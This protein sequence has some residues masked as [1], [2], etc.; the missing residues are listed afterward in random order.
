MSTV[1]MCRQPA[2]PHT[3]SCNLIRPTR[4]SSPNLI[5]LSRLETI[6]Q[7][8][9]CPSASQPSPHQILT[10]GLP[11]L[12]P[13]AVSPNRLSTPPLLGR[14]SDSLPRDGSSPPTVLSGQHQSTVYLSLPLCRMPTSITKHLPS[15]RRAKKAFVLEMP[16][17]S[18]PRS[19]SARC[20]ALLL[21]EGFRPEQPAGA[22]IGGTPSA[23][24]AKVDRNLDR[25]LD[26]RPPR[27]QQHH[28]SQRVSWA[29]SFL[30]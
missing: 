7:L 9:D 20:K 6:S 26:M 13:E 4:P 5:N 21:T 15:F 23:F 24:Q 12:C 2:G 28:C 17:S 16:D 1:S 8:R 25:D 29:V 3:L 18:H 14:N 27:Q 30:A 19:F 11:L 22:C 10:Q